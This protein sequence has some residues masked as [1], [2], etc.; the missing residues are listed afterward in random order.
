MIQPSLSKQILEINGV[1]A[2]P[3]HIYDPS[4]PLFKVWKA[5]LNQWKIMFNIGVYNHRERG[6]PY[7][8][9]SEIKEA[10]YGHQ[11]YYNEATK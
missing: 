8:T 3:A 7:M 9:L 2:E 5:V 4:Y 1:G 11:R 6:V 10:W